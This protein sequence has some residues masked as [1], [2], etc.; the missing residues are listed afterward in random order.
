MHHI[1]AFRY[2]FIVIITILIVNCP[3]LS[4]F[5]LGKSRSFNSNYEKNMKT[6]INIHFN[7][8]VSLLNMSTYLSRDKGL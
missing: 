2:Y 5:W 6:N 1:L 4:N 3:Q 8:S 7:I